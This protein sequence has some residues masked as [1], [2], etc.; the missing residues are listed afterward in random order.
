[1]ARRDALRRA[2]EEA[3]GEHAARAH[4]DERRAL[5]H[6][7]E[8]LDARREQVVHRKAQLAQRADEG[9]HDRLQEAREAFELAQAEAERAT[10]EATVVKHLH[11]T[12]TAARDTLQQRFAGPVREAVE[13]SVGV[14]FPAPPCCST[15]TAT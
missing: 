15:K 6:L 12:L 13:A 5:E 8:R 1:V 7:D 9:L 14:L 3:G 2:F 4:A 10:H 11:D